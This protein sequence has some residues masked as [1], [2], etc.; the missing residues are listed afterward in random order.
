MRRTTLIGG[1]FG[2]L[3]TLSCGPIDRIVID[4]STAGGEAMLVRLSLSKVAASTV[5]RAEIVVTGPG[6]RKCF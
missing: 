2:L 3:T 6:D 5:D 1:F 4:D